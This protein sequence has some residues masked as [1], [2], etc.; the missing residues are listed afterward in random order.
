MSLGLL[1]DEG[2]E[3]RGEGRWY[4]GCGIWDMGYVS[5]ASLPTYLVVQEQKLE[6]FY[7]CIGTMRG[8]KN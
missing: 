3:G 5:V 1:R 4:I 7:G 8:K 6:I 2:Y